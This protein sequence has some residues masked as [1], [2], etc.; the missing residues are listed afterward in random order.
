MPFVVPRE[1]TTF[2]IAVP[3]RAGR[4]TRTII[5]KKMIKKKQNKTLDKLKTFVQ[6]R[7][8]N[9]YFAFLSGPSL[10]QYSTV[11]SGSLFGGGSI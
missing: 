2:T 10:C 4:K 9:R 7:P 3:V 1:H 11:V 6:A 8:S 5:I